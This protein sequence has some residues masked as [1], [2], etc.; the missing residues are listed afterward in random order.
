MT[1]DW[2]IRAPPPVPPDGGAD[3]N[4]NPDS[5][6][7]YTSFRVAVSFQQEAAADHL[8]AAGADPE[9]ALL[10]SRSYPSSVINASPAITEKLLAA[11]ANP[12]R[13]DAKGVTPLKLADHA[14]V[15]RLLSLGGDPNIRTFFG[16]TPSHQGAQ[17]QDVAIVESL[18]RSGADFDVLT[19]DGYTSLHGAPRT[20]S[21]DI[22]TVLLAA[23][24]EVQKETAHG[25]TPYRIAAQRSRPAVA[26][27]LLAAAAR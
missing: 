7:A 12:H 18:L 4:S 26:A 19:L 15:A 21:A 27:L 10:S 20:G 25:E 1:A 13:P 2:G 9:Q 11:G 24:P 23:G 3:P 5:R 16:E 14:R 6:G 17:G 22:V 8:L